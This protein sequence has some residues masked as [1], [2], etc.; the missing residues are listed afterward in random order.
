SQKLIWMVR[1][2]HPTA[3]PAELGAQT[4]LSRHTVKRGLARL[5][6][7]NPAPAGPRVKVPAS[8]LAEHRVGAQAKVLYGLLQATPAYRGQTGQ[9]T[10]TG[11]CSLTR[12]SRNTLKRAMAE[13]SA[14]GWVQTTQ[15]TRLSSIAFTLGSPELMRSHTETAAAKRRLK[16]ANHG[17]EAIMQ[18]YLSLLIDSNQFTDNARPGFLV[19][20]LTGERLELDRFYPPN[21][22]FEFHGTQHDSATE[23]FT[24]QEVDTQRLRDLIKAGICLY[25]GI[26]LV[27]IRAEDLSLQGMIHKIG[28]CMP[29]RDLAGHEF[30]L[31]LLEGE[32]LKYRASAPKPNEPTRA[33]K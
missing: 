17:G 10:Y 8:L 11:L 18:E 16:R 2:L 27:I 14:A 19:N 20:P 22:A 3:S 29:L 31:D 1:R 25:Q 30:L 21:V 6:A 13:L 24:Q 26:H 33:A 4:G 15:K 7:G 23:K 9:F 5:T 12:L 32:S 28:R